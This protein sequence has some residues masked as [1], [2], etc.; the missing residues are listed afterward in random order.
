MIILG[1]HISEL[2][3]CN[4]TYD[5]LNLCFSEKLN[6]YITINN[7]HTVTLAV[8]NNKYREIINHSFL[9]F[10]DGKLLSIYA[11][12]KGNKEITRIF[13]PIFFLRRH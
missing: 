8:K 11:K 4:Q 12:L 2:I 6:S 10:P 1:S 7:V 3:S 9:S 5:I 13:G